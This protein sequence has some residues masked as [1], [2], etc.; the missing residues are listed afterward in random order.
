MSYPAK[1]LGSKAINKALERHV[2]L[3]VSKYLLKYSFCFTLLFSTILSTFY[4]IFRVY[5]SSLSSLQIPRD[6]HMISCRAMSSDDDNRIVE[7]KEKFNLQLAKTPG[8][9]FLVSCV[10]GTT[11]NPKMA[12]MNSSSEKRTKNGVAFV[13]V[14]RTEA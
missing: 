6:S 9:E 10:T 3:S 12:I 11:S 8:V 5:I 2:V 1:S 13:I 4:I 14:T 7:M